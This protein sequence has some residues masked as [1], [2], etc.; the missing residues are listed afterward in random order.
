MYGLALPAVSITLSLVLAMLNRSFRWLALPVVPASY[1][2]KQALLGVVLLLAAGCG[3]S[4]SAQDRLVRGPG[5]EFSAP[6]DW[7][8]SKTAAETRLEQRDGLVSVRRFGLARRF[9]PAQFAK[10]VPELDRAAAAVALQQGG[11]VRSPETVTIGGRDARRYDIEYEKNGRKLVDRIAFVL[12][13]RTE[14]YLLCR[15]EAGGDTRACE[16]LLATFRL[17]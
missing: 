2:R 11:Q 1:P 7:A 12:R 3:G 9:R 4:N 8:L 16:R 15:Y 17:T 6:A 5:Y 13:D 14:Y 10:V